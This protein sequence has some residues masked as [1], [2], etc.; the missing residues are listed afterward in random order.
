MKQINLF[1]RLAFLLA[2]VVFVISSCSNNDSESQLEEQKDITQ[3]EQEEKVEPKPRL[4]ISLDNIEKQ[5]AWKNVDFAFRL[6]QSADKSIK[7]NDKLVLSPF[8]ASMA[9][10][11]LTN[12]AGGDSK[13]E[14][15]EALGYNANELATMNRLNKRLL[16]EL[17]ELDNTTTVGIAN[18][19]WLNKGI[20]VTGEFKDVLTTD[21][22]AEVNTLDYSQVE[23]VGIINEWC[24]KKT[25]NLIKNF[26]EDLRPNDCFILLNALYFNGEWKTPF[27]PEKTNKAIFTA[28]NG[29]Q[30]E[31]E[32]MHK[33][34]S[35]MYVKENGYA[36][37][38]LPYGN[39]AYS[40]FILMPDTGI[41]ISECIES[42]T[43]EGWMDSMNEMKFKLIS[44]KLPKF[45]TEA[46]LSMGGTL[47][48][49]GVEKVFL[50][51]SANLTALSGDKSYLSGMMQA[52]NI[53]VDEYG[54]EAAAVTGNT[55]EIEGGES[56]NVEVI[57][58]HVNRS[59]LFFVKEKSTDTFLFIGKMADME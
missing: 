9:L 3:E 23:S 40:M 4:D 48:V 12:G 35:Y 51:D 55:T 16:E 19:L 59:F 43:A 20:T 37:V 44:V 25:N 34:S 58:F 50:P 42:I 13:Q 14:L 1:S 30:Q 32:M 54:T 46:K 17:P 27:V 28:Q 41:G 38:E 2:M 15:L 57:D 8:S 29:E 5:L 45:K 49:M 22:S 52:I 18:S 24:K 6:L 39:S 47:H 53:S 11:M 33:I 36:M 56:G 26:L 10:S 7:N 21:Y 31:V